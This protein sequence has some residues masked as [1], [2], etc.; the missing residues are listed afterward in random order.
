MDSQICN[1]CGVE[2]ELYVKN[3]RWRNDCNNW[4]RICNECK[5]KVIDAWTVKNKEKMD[6]WRKEW[7]K[8]YNKKYYNDNKE[9]EK[10]RC[11]N[12]PKEMLNKYSRKRMLK[13]NNKIRRNISRSISYHL[14]KSGGK[15]KISHLKFVD[16][17]YDDLVSHLE[18]LFEP[19]MNWD[20]YGVYRLDKWDDNDSST[21]TWQ[22][23]HIIPHSSFNYTTMDCQ[24][25]KDC[26][27]LTNLRPYSSKQNMLDRD[28]KQLLQM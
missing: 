2:K 4:N 20:N 8:V 9:K 7:D 17:K 27:A 24:E 28:R 21:W 23:D 19:W 18:S 6:L 16:W 5:R 13:N 1:K 22:I 26:W 10:L 3:F 25:F 15:N 11:R 12:K 14:F